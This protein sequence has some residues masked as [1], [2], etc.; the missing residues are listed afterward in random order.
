ERRIE[1]LLNPDLSGLPAFLATHPGLESGYM[2]AQ[3]TAVDL[4]GEMRA[5]AHPVSVDS[6]PTSANQ[7]DHVSMGLAAARKARRSVECLQYVL[8]VELLCGARAL[9]HRRPLRSGPAVEAVYER[10]RERAPARE[11]DRPLADELEAVKELV[12]EG[13]LTPAA[14]GSQE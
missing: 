7:E 3:V 1:R 12:A 5:L 10:I 9:E 11:G 4:L 13:G 6:A 14:L 2:I 8:A